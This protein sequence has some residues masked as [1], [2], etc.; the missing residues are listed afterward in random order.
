MT[1]KWITV[2]E[3]TQRMGKREGVTSVKEVTTFAG[4]FLVAENEHGAMLCRARIYDGTEHRN[5]RANMVIDRDELGP[6]E[7]R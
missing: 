1:D 7:W 3:A 2:D 6:R 4:K 5:A